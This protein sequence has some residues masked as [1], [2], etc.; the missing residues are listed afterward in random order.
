[1]TTTD[2][3]ARAL[4]AELEERIVNGDTSIN[5]AAL[6][7]ARNAADFAEFQDEA[8]RRRADHE[9]TTERQRLEDEFRTE[10]AAQAAQLASVQ[11]AYDA[12]VNAR[13]MFDQRI[14]DWQDARRILQLRART[15]GLTDVVDAELVDLSQRNWTDTLHN[16]AA[17]LFER[18]AARP[19]GQRGAI[20]HHVL[21]GTAS[22]ERIDR[23]DE[24]D[25][26]VR[27]E[28]L[29]EREE[30]RRLARESV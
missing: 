30:H 26:A 15:L 6:A 9:A 16:E 2:T 14:A 17:G 22:R 1:M 3:D 11:H 4:L 10:I 29:R 8:A 21:R 28:R 5:A 7:K 18:G 19:F 13:R 27:A 23:E 24:A 12:A 25:A 20:R